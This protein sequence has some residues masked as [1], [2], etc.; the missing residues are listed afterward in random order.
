[1][2]Y[3][4]QNVSYSTVELRMYQQ[5]GGK[6][7]FDPNKGAALSDRLQSAWIA[8]L[9]V[10]AVVLQGILVFLAAALPILLL[11][12]VVLIPAVYY[13]RRRN[14]RLAETRNQLKQQNTSVSSIPNE[15]TEPS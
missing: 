5:T 10:L 8:S 12:A 6:S 9:N 2:R 4:D 15:P 3:L 11:A 1:M 13:R 7:P 14:Q